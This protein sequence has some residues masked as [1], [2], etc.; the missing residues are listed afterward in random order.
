MVADSFYGQNE[1]FRSGL[2]RLKVGYVLALQPSFA[3]WHTEGAIGS[4]WEAAQAA[5]WRGPKEPGHWERVVGTLRDA[6]REDGWA[7]EVTTSP[8]GPEKPLRAAVVSTDPERLP[9]HSTW[10]LVSDLP[11]PG[12]ARAKESAL[13]PASVEEIVRV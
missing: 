12:S 3:W 5:L 13:A 2:E 4:V 9:D 11:A 8:F 10:F 7:L 6:H 1:Q